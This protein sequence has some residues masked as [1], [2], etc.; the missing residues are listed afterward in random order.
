MC[1]MQYD[2]IHVHA[3]KFSNLKKSSTE[4]SKSLFN[5]PFGETRTDKITYKKYSQTRFLT[6]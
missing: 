5:Q 2:I 6:A 1:I 4:Q 3:I